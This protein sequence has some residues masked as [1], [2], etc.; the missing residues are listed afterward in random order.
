MIRRNAYRNF[1]KVVAGF[2]ALALILSCPGI[3]AAGKVQAT[4]DSGREMYHTEALD[5]SNY[6]GDKAPK[7]QAEEYKDWLFSGWFSDESCISGMELKEK[8]MT[9]ICYAKFV[10]EEVLS[11]KCQIT[12][13]LSESSEEPGKMRIVST[14]DSLRYQNVGFEIKYGDNELMKHNTRTV[15]DK[16]AA[17][18]GVPFTYEP[19]VF[20][21]VSKYFITA[22]LINIP[23]EAFDT[24]I[25]IAPYWVTMDGTL[26]YG[27]SRYARVEDGYRNIVNVPVRLYS[28]ESV[29]SGYLEID[30][31]EEKMEY[32]PNKDDS[33][34]L[35]NVFEEME[36]AD[37]E[38][39]GNRMIRCAGNVKD[40]TNNKIADGLYVNLRF[41][42]KNG[43]PAT[44]ETF[45]VSSETFCN[46]QEEIIDGF[47][48]SDV[49]YK[50]MGAESQIEPL[51]EVT[52]AVRTGGAKTEERKV[53]A[54][55]VKPNDVNND[56]Y[57]DIRDIVRMKLYLNSP[58][59]ATIYSVELNDLD[60]SGVIDEKD[61]VILRRNLVNG[62]EIVSLGDNLQAL[63]GTDFEGF[64]E[65]ASVEIVKKWVNDCYNAS[66]GKVLIMNGKENAYVKLLPAANAGAAILTKSC[67]TAVL[68]AGTYRLSFDVKLG[69]KA[70][71]AISFGI[72]D[73]KAWAPQWPKVTIDTTGANAD[74]WTTVTYEFT[75][76][77]DKTGTY[78]NLDL[79]YTCVTA[80]EDN[81]VL[82][83]NV[84]LINK[85]T[86]QNVDTGKHGDFEGFF[87]KLRDLLRT[88][89]WKADKNGNVIFVSEGVL[90]NELVTE[91]NGNKCFKF[92][93][94]KGPSTLVNFAGNTAIAKA[95]IY[96]MS[97]KVKLGP[98]ASKVDNI[99]F[100]LHAATPLN[101]GDI[102]F[103][104]LEKLNSSEWVTL[105]AYFVVPKTVTT[106]YVNMN[107]WVFTHN[108]E[109]GSADNYV[110]MDDIE[111]REVKTGTA[112]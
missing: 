109:I 75:L 58:D 101:A 31:D 98:D 85:A 91:E 61:L 103:K 16:I 66:A 5:I 49:V 79:A 92:Y 6:Q 72:W 14:V 47:H 76:P 40:I 8:P 26:V 96:K 97:V 44:D 95:G 21:D 107:F 82:I 28:E 90:E 41:L 48:V 42:A 104:G 34:D 54:E 9:G 83:D 18:N 10:P 53:S 102:T 94:A 106:N 19:T 35:G 32:Y 3:G 80:D 59:I 65:D 64:E 45:A 108:D 33:Y 29:A 86:N 89:G 81:Y 30:Y 105:E 71:G 111:V 63:K 60:G 11:V 20:S 57:F 73:G 12:D 23:T 74:T 4:G 13:E 78:A 112:G 17:T 24:G 77:A 51:G 68:K 56:G 22:T 100:R 70:D 69:D 50:G 25:Y 55:A 36:I 2:V 1:R 62:I 38:V 37:I 87:T 110:L 27:V 93:T 7:P 52:A 39:N 15:Y 67:N 43:I 46:N 88:S 84:Q 99:G